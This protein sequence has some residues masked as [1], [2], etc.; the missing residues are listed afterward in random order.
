MFRQAREKL[1]DLA[2]NL[3]ETIRPISPELRDSAGGRDRESTR[4][5]FPI[6]DRLLVASAQQLK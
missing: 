1:G 4:R 2:G 5:M 3:V 6:E